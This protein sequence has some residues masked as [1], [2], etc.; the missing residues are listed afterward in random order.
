[1][2]RA[3][4]PAAADGAGERLL[5]RVSQHVSF[6]MARQTETLPALFARVGPQVGVAPPVLAEIPRGGVAAVAVRTLKG[7]LPGVRPLVLHQIARLCETF[8]AFS[9][10]V[11]PLPGVGALVVSQV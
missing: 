5:P 6:Q 10:F 7:L 9:A 8:V 11:G 1:M 4:K 2:V 3:S